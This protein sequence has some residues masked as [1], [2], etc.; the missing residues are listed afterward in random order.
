M[1]GRP[2][3]CSAQAGV[4]AGTIVQLTALAPTML[5]HS[6]RNS[7]GPA[8]PT[9]GGQLIDASPS[10]PARWSTARAH[11][12]TLFSLLDA[13]DV[14]FR[15]TFTTPHL[16]TPPGAPDK[17]WPPLALREHQRWRA[18]LGRIVRGGA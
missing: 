2:K 18:Q 8:L 11:L 13:V 15:G 3:T 7:R 5:I 9:R 1:S 6:D 16:A 17:G 4:G 12:V 14:L 10:A